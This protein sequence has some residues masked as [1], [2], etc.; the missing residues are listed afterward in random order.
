MASAT[1][2]SNIR[3]IHKPDAECVPRPAAGYFFKP[4]PDA[5][6]VPL[7][8]AAGY[9]RVGIV[10]HTDETEKM[11]I[12]GF[13]AGVRSERDGMARIYVF[14]KNNKTA[15]PYTIPSELIV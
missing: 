12:A 2:T 8:P 5:E 9:T 11:E 4:D 10:E 3:V 7:R 1:N 15:G 6:Y 14:L 13:P